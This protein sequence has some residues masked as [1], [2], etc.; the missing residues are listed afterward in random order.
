MDCAPGIR[1]FTFLVEW[2][3]IIDSVKAIHQTIKDYITEAVVERE[4]EYE[5]MLLSK[6][7]GWCK[8]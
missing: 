7:G 6:L 3:K 1:S 4:E 2:V 8:D 5:V